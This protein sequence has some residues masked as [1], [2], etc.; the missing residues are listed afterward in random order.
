MNIK[1]IAHVSYKTSDMEKALKFYRDGL[2]FKE[3]FSLNDKQGRPWLIYL[4]IVSGQFIE[5]FYDYDRLQNEQKKDKKIGYLHLSIEVNDIR[6]MKEDLINKGITLDSDIGMEA[7]HTYQLWVSDPDGNRIE[8][9][10]YTKESLQ[11]QK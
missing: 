5:I 11:I 7:D 10:E 9:M 1:G 2:G 3:K 4:E 8:F 6:K